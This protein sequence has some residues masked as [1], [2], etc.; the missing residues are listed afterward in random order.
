MES[1]SL[2]GKTILLTGA[3]SG[4]GRVMAHRL[5]GM[6]ASLMVV[7]RNTTKGDQLIGEITTATGNKDVVFLTADLSSMVEVQRLASEINSRTEK[8][9]VLINNA[10][11][12]FF[13]HRLSPDGYEMS[14][15]LN[16]LS[17][18]LLTN[19][20]IDRIKAA[21]AGRIITTSSVA[22]QTAKL[23]FNDLMLEK[24]YKP[25]TAYSNSKLANI[26]FTYQL[27]KNLAGTNTTANTLHPGFVRTNFGRSNG[28][29]VGMLTAI[30]QIFAIS[31]DAGASTSIYLA[32]SPDVEGVTGKYFVRCKPV[33][34]SEY[35]YNETAALQLWAISLKLTG[36]A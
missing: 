1:S 15:A 25:W 19:L 21:P 35:S 3:T 5:A 9:D 20:I 33:K 31:P 6:G 22:H 28:G 27:A 12:V 34:S 10:G 8:I 2:M 30:S 16:H 18:F 4:I 29:G 32:S 17:P 13:Q 26:L 7:G 11:A 24:G 14:L 36:L 23:D